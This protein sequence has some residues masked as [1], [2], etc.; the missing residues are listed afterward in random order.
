MGSSLAALLIMA[1]FFT[2]VILMYRTT[3]SG[4][5]GVSRSIREASNDSL[6]RTR[7]NLQITS[8]FTSDQRGE[9]CNVFAG[10]DNIGSVAIDDF[11][12]MDVIVTMD[13]FDGSLDTKRFS[14]TSPASAADSDSWSLAIDTNTYPYE[15]LTLNPGESG[16]MTINW[17]MTGNG[18]P[19]A[20]H[21][22]GNVG[23]GGTVEIDVLNNDI[24]A[25]GEVRAVTIGAAN[26]VTTERAASIGELM[27]LCT[28][29]AGVDTL[30]IDSVTQGV[31]GAVAISLGGRVT[32][33]HDGSATTS[34][35]FTY[36]VRDGNGGTDTGTVVVAIA[37]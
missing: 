4:N 9:Q 12:N 7:T 30:T 25:D 17:P 1:V 26:G 15:P 33:V 29:P 23:N 32:Y 35:S 24:D 13:T 8:L 11:A 28:N 2:G 21:D 16:L 5:V 31:N 34:D 6:E 10:I 18:I 22:T 19:V 27:G 20:V 36:V 37:P 3:L 14:V